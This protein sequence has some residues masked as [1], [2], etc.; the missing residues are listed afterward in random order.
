MRHTHQ[1]HLEGIGV[2]GSNVYLIG[3]RLPDNKLLSI[4]RVSVTNETNG[5][6]SATVG[7]KLG[8]D[9]V[10]LETLL[11]TTAGYYYALKEPVFVVGAKQVVVRF[12]STTDGDKLKANVFGYYRD[13]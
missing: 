7:V 12:G 11:I 10:W 3:R 13:T 4:Q 2:T 9:I 6:V 1:D 5:T 8:S